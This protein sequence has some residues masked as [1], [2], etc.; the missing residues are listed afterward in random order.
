MSESV[1]EESC[2]PLSCSLM[3]KACPFFWEN[4]FSFSSES[5]NARGYSHPPLFFFNSF[6]PIFSNIAPCASAHTDAAR[7]TH[8]CGICS[9]SVPLPSCS[10]PC[11]QPVRDTRSG[12]TGWPQTPTAYF[13]TALVC[14]S[15]SAADRPSGIWF[16]QLGSFMVKVKRARVMS[17]T[18][19]EKKK[20]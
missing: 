17:Q 12:M 19:E 7:R 11:H 14:P 18:S 10:S 8:T 15:D 3:G 20:N 16:C 13:V 4:K 2:T 5:R 6:L 1:F 9:A